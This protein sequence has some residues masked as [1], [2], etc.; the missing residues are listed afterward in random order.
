M[1]S[2]S[3]FLLAI[4]LI[5]SCACAA[6]GPNFR[7][8]QLR[9]EYL[10]DPLG[11]DTPQ[12]RLSWI[13]ASS[14]RGVKQV[15]CQI[16][17]AR[18]EAALKTNQADLWDSGKVASDETAQIRYAG[19]PLRSRERCFWKVR[20]WDQRGQS[21]DSPVA[22]W[23]MG[24]LQ[25]SDWQGQWIARTTDT[26]S[27]PA[28]LLRR[29]FQLDGQIKQARVYLCGLGYYELYLN[30]QKVGDHV[31]DPGYTRYDKRD[32]YVTYDVTDLLKRG[33]NAVG[34]MLGNGWYNVQTKAV[35]N[36]HLAP[37]RAAPKLLLQL[38][39]DYADGHSQT[40]VSDASWKSS[41]GPIQF[42][43]I[44]GGETYD[45][46]LEK[47]G[48][49]TAGYDDTQWEPVKLVQAPQGKLVAQMMPPIKIDET[50]KPVEVT[51]PKPG[52][53]VYDI[54]QNL[55]G[56]CELRV[57]GPAGTQVQMRYGERLFPDGTLDTRDIAQHV[58]RMGTN[59]QFQTDTY[60]LKGSA[61][62]DVA[63]ALLLSRL[64]V[65]GGHGLPWPAD[66]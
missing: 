44:Y 41:T 49:A 21:A 17:V 34:V 12:P 15:A 58:K 50:L 7:V 65:C 5:C 29:T 35:W 14:E 24:L 56:F 40:I 47:P 46:R 25:P 30:S 3:A 1:K 33:P 61:I 22:H 32:L 62:G 13:L 51:Q 53:F 63:R 39:V 59:Q 10:E 20:V 36:F 57:Q 18:S 55:A 6:T 52:V 54:G 43:S 42:D 31:L 38:R 64:P 45:A 2:F 23:E 9:C 28:P 60:I 4:A 11:I 8:D 26:N 48:W 19:Q 66:T 37:W 16:L 27:F